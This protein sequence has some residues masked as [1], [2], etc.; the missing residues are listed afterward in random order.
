[1][2]MHPQGRVASRVERLNAGID[3]SKDHLDVSVGPEQFQVINDAKGWDGLA[4]KL[5]SLEVDVVV[6]EATGGIERG[7]VCTLQA[8]GLSVARVNPR[9]A[10]DF[11]KSMGALAK[12]DR[13]DAR[14]LRDFADV[15]ARHENRAK[16]ISP[17]RDPQREALAGLMVRRRQLV[18]MRVAEEHR[19]THADKRA[20]Q[21]IRTMLKAI[22]RQVN[23]IDDDIDQHLNEHFKDQRKLLESV[24][25]VGTVTTLQLLAALPE[26]GKL[27]RRPICKLAG[28]A[29]LCDDS[30]KRSGKRRIW[31][32]RAEVRTALYMATLSAS[33]HNPVIAA[34]Y[35]QLV[36]AGK[37][38]KVALVAC[39]RK[40]LTI[41]NAM[42]RD[43]A[44][45]EPA[46]ALAAGAST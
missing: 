24:K 3:V 12:T 40:L 44:S 22:E 23:L 18:D 41:L 46:R 1:M 34:K 10:R 28:L 42:M 39:M 2:N 8:A 33:R 36:A 45:W 5:K 17:T 27:S 35:Q 20:A 25:G 9:Q 30:G 15:L 19:L 31:G 14:C 38:K 6:V 7:V 4:A 16:Y 29:P 32:G 26:L 21:S 11:A 37:P 43:A 13:I